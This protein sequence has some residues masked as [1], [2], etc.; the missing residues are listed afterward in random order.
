MDL[1]SKK[2]QLIIGIHHQPEFWI[3]LDHFGPPPLVTSG[4]SSPSGAWNTRTWSRK[5][6]HQA[7]VR[8]RM[9]PTHPDQITGVFMK[10]LKISCNHII[11]DLVAELA[12]HMC[13]LDAILIRTKTMPT[14]SI[15]KKV[16]WDQIQPNKLSFQTP[17]TASCTVSVLWLL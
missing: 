11:I 14:S 7:L 8:N 15:K 10:S 3:I 9:T 13:I 4:F 12:C 2:K 6:E 16:D 5:L 17:K 1:S